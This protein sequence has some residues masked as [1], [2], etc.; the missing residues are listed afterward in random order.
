[1]NAESDISVKCDNYQVWVAHFDVLGF[2]SM[3][4]N[5]NYSLALKVL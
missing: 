4:N 2:K 1:M 5:S 3:I